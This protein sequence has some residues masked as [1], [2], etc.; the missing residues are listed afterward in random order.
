MST[1]CCVIGLQSTGEAS[2]KDAAKK[3]G[4]KDEAVMGDFVS[5][6]QQ[7]LRK[8]I[9]SVF[10]LA[11]KPRGVIPPDFI[12]PKM[13]TI[14][15]D[16][17]D[18]MADG[19]DGGNGGT[20]DESEAEAQPTSRRMPSGRPG[21]RAATQKKIS[22][23]EDTDC[24]ETDE[25]DIIPVKQQRGRG[26]K[27]T[28]AG[29][30]KSQSQLKKKRKIATSDDS[31]S[32]DEEE[33]AASDSDSSDDES[34][35][36]SDDDEEMETDRTNDDG[37]AFGDDQ[38]SVERIAWDEIDMSLVGDDVALGKMNPR[39][40]LEYERRAEYRKSVEQ[41]KRW[42]DE[43]DKLDLPPNPLDRLLNEL[44]GPD[45]VAEMTGRKTRMIQQID[46][47]TGKQIVSYEKRVKTN[48]DA[49]SINIEERQY[50]QSGKKHIAIISEAA[51][52]GVSLHADRRVENQRRRVHLT[53][54]LPWSADKAIQQLGRTHRSNQSSGP[55]YRFLVSDVGGE[56]RFASAV[57]KRL[58]SLGAL[59]QGDRRTSGS[60][61]SLGLSAFDV[62]NAYG[63]TALKNMCTAVTN[64]RKSS[65][66]PV[67]TDD[68]YRDALGRIDLVLIEMQNNNSNILDTADATGMAI[69]EIS[70]ILTCINKGSNDAAKRLKQCRN[71]A[72]KEEQDLPSLIEQ[73]EGLGEDEGLDEEEKEQAAAL[74]QEEIK[75]QVELAKQKGLTSEMIV[76]IWFHDV[77]FDATDVSNTS[78]K[79]TSS[80]ILSKFLNR[81]LGMPLKQ[82]E[83]VT[84][85]FYA[86]LEKV[87]LEAKR[88]DKYDVGI[89][90]LTGRDVAFQ[91][92][93]RTFK[94]RGLDAPH[95]SVQLYTV[96]ADTGITAT[97]AQELL[98]DHQRGINDGQEPEEQEASPGAKRGFGMNSAS[99]W[100]IKSGFYIDDRPIF[101]ETAKVFLILA[102]P[103]LAKLSG[104]VT[105]VR[106]N[107]GI[108][109]VKSSDIEEKI[110]YKRTL[111][112]CKT[113]AQL[114][115][116]LK[117]WTTEFDLADIAYEETYQFSCPGRI[118]ESRVLTGAVV[119][120]LSKV[121]V[122]LDAT[123]NGDDTVRSKNMPKVTRV[124]TANNAGDG[125]KDDDAASESDGEG[126]ERK[127]PPADDEEEDGTKSA[128]GNNDAMVTD[129]VLSGTGDQGSGI[130]RKIEGQGIMRGRIVRFK[131]D[132]DNSGETSKV[133]GTYFVELSSGE[134]LQWD[135]ART[136]EG[137]NLYE[138]EIK[139]L[140]ECKMSEEV[141][142]SMQSTKTAS[143]DDHPSLIGK[144]MIMDVDDDQDVEGF[145]EE[146]YEIQL[147]EELPRSIIGL[148]LP[149]R[150]MYVG[151]EEKPAWQKGKW[152][153]I[154]SFIAPRCSFFYDPQV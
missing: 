24:E 10:P 95:E 69:S 130:A 146:R 16:E 85:F 21:R 100:S 57:A 11:P 104:K 46:D 49:D 73:L 148:E 91:G 34:E 109:Q 23:T 111:K 22:Y 42:Y 58:Q 44:G 90:T 115:R 105:Q 89:K 102:D 99:A 45:K 1:D 87:V 108:A 80:N 142:R 79:K 141:A 116:A 136:L 78:R 72:I 94:F 120:L 77:G 114:E 153:R 2:A 93:P 8:T 97:A 131:S 65:T 28:S 129:I 40:K 82:Q 154:V 86:R 84:N 151:G 19:G 83:I 53:L 117:A 5:A 101:Q 61:N 122:L 27:P 121:M 55:A 118:R 124:E 147:K 103:E 15:E 106:P 6:P 71:D 52:T 18:A 76:S 63:Q 88:S 119:P 54:E 127:M 110:R 68:Q 35:A 140:L 17:D 64:C 56:A 107:T 133:S 20:D 123:P 150:N 92:A 81:V 139:K 60:A 74:V 48:R 30:K 143:A 26:R 12:Y 70:A 152:P 4:V 3:A 31:D 128:D 51:S 33:A 50:F 132:D 134:K 36:F 98:R 138:D 14:N 29:G 7:A 137:R 37:S 112:L 145:L 125:D 126:N 13:E 144:P 135:A 66:S 75:S 47:R 96:Q 39:E 32:E 67:L 25:D 9:L 38:G 43:V 62:D 113:K 59:T 41:I 149:T